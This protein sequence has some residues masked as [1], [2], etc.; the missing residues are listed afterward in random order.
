[1][2]L[3]N[4]L[5]DLSVVETINTLKTA[6]LLCW[7]YISLIGF[8]LPLEN[9]WLT[10]LIWL[11]PITEL[12]YHEGVSG[13]ILSP[14]DVHFFNGWTQASES[15]YLHH[16]FIVIKIPTKLGFKQFGLKA[17]HQFEWQ[18]SFQYTCTYMDSYHESGCIISSLLQLCMWALIVCQSAPVKLQRSKST[19][20]GAKASLGW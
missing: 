11:Y 17:A 12:L 19:R 4:L 3:F 13:L 8:C 1:M 7:E 16:C 6:E 2:S 5:F 15:N 14:V 9:T 20:S 10:I 18:V